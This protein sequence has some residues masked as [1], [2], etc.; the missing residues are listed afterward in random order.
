MSS[1]AI[2]YEVIV[3]PP[4]ESDT[5]G[6]CFVMCDPYQKLNIENTTTSKVVD[7]VKKFKPTN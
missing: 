4:N 5:E 3:T 1:R 2:H 7:Y 6:D